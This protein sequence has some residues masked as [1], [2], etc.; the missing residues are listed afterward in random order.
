MTATEVTSLVEKQ[1]ALIEVARVQERI[2]RFLVSPYPVAGSWDYGKEDQ[3]YVC[4]IVL[5]HRESESGIAYCEEGF[6]PAMPWGLMWLKGSHRYRIGM[7][8][9]WFDSLVDAFRESC[10]W[11]EPP[12]SS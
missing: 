7:D 2:R 11:E 1:L 4:W 8:S 12:P 3:T 6:G 5:E 9:G 10:A